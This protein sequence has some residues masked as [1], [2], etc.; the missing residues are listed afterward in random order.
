MYVFPYTIIGIKIY[1]YR[2][3]RT[4]VLTKWSFVTIG[5]EVNGQI[6][7]FYVNKILHNDGWGPRTWQF[8]KIICRVLIGPT[9]NCA[10]SLLFLFVQILLYYWMKSWQIG[11]VILSLVINVVEKIYPINGRI[12]VNLLFYYIWDRY[13]IK[14]K[15]HCYFCQKYSDYQRQQ[16]AA[17][18]FVCGLL[19]CFR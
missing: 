9:R 14:R 7:W 10:L 4:D 5:K 19:D 17:F 16:N 6:N 8:T 13:E 3:P 11:E 15:R 12:W 2:S 1:S 18:L